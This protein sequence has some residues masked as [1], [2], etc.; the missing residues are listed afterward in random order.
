MTTSRSAARAVQDPPL[1]D[2]RILIVDDQEAN[3]RL[4]ENLLGRSGY[5]NLKTTTNPREVPAL[6]AEFSPDLILL[7][8]VMPGLDGFGV[9]EALRG[10]VPV[11]TYLPV[12]VLTADITSEAKERALASGAKDF[13]TKPFDP[14]EV[15]LRIR[16]L[17]ETRWLHL[18]LQDR[19]R[20]LE[21]RV[22]ARTEDLEEAQIE[23]LERLAL[24]AEYRDDLTGRHTQR[25]GQH[26]GVLARARGLA[27]DQVTLIRRAATLHDVGKIV[28]PD[29]LLL[30]PVNLGPEEF[31]VLKAH[32]TIGARILSGSRFPL[33]QMAAEIALAHHERWDGKG[34]PEGLRGEAIPLPARIVAVVDAFDEL[35]N[36][37]PYRKAISRQ[38]ALEILE[39]GAGSQWD[40]RLVETFASMRH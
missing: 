36:D 22:S 21:A 29:Y 16:N 40:K 9:M 34:Y 27:D 4:L 20:M 17:L 5:T 32:T 23:I 2:A 15:L 39:R 11:A 3:T 6:Y 26:A 31:E 35:T 10:L 25:V 37:R 24:A 28:I 38:Q 8:L 33:L 12:L 1:L 7:D 18:R 19:N 30:K 13:L 14:A